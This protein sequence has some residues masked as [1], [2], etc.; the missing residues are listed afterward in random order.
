MIRDDYLVPHSLLAPRSADTG[1]GS[2]KFLNNGIP[3]KSSSGTS[4]PLPLAAE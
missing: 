3:E 1:G 2:L 4:P